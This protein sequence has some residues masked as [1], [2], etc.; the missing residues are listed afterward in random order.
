MILNNNKENGDN[1][2]III[3]KIIISQTT[4]VNSFLK[5][6][7][8]RIAQLREIQQRK[9]EGKRIQQ[10][11]IISKLQ[12]AGIL[13]ENGELSAPYRNDDTWRIS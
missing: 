1:M 3:E 10:N 11:R 6:Q 13:D 9:M 2:A 7:D 8:R 12:R 5:K 4:Q